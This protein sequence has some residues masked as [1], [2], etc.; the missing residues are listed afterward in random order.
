[1]RDQSFLLK[2]KNAYFGYLDQVFKISTVFLTKV[3][4]CEVCCESQDQ[5]LI[6]ILWINLIPLLYPKLWAHYD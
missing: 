5:V 6:S 2:F 3:P 1:M 4:T